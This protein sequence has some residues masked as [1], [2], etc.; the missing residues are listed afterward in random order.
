MQRVN[1]MIKTQYDKTYQSQGDFEL[2]TVPRKGDYFSRKE[3]IYLV[4]YVCFDEING[5]DIFLIETNI[6]S[7][8]VIE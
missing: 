6:S 3:T 4:E 8:A 7:L 1:L 2:S 5:A